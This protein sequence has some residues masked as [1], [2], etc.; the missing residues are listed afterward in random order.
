MRKCKYAGPNGARGH[1]LGGLGGRSGWYEILKYTNEYVRPPLLSLGV[2]PLAERY[3]ET[4]ATHWI[5]IFLH[6]IFLPGCD[7]FVLLVYAQGCWAIS[8]VF[9]KGKTITNYYLHFC[10]A[11]SV[12]CPTADLY[13]VTLSLPCLDA[14][15]DRDFPI[16]HGE[17][18][19]NPCRTARR[20]KL[21]WARWVRNIAFR[22]HQKCRKMWDLFLESRRIYQLALVRFSKFSLNHCNRRQ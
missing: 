1:W 22:P 18:F 2:S 17:P 6:Q 5:H 7:S 15:L 16:F 3:I 8:G 4:V 20:S 19:S 9:L 12:V 11:H 21:F 14:V 10:Y 13:I